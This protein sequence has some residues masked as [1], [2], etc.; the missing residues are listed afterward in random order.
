MS[1][2]N[3]EKY[4]Y[5][6]LDSVLTQEDVSVD[7]YVRDDGSTD[8]TIDI[9]QKY[10]REYSNVHLI[11]DGN[12]V[13]PGQSFY[14]LMKYISKN[15]PHDFYA[16]SDQDDIWMP[17]KLYVGIEKI[18]SIR[19]PALYASNQWLYF[20]GEIKGLRF[21]EMDV[22]LE[23]ELNGNDISGCT[24]VFNHDMAKLASKKE[25]PDKMLL[26]YRLHDTMLLLIALIS[27]KFVFD[28]DS[29]IK[30]RIHKDNAVGIK[31]LGLIGKLKRVIKPGNKDRWWR[32]R[33]KTARYLVDNFSF[34]QE[35][36]LQFLRLYSD[37]NKSIRGRILLMNNQRVLR[38]I[39]ESKFRFTVKVLLG[40]V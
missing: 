18:K 30:Y 15:Y 5:E 8:S 27:G 2:Y 10:S 13:G 7:L 32:A 24:M 34:T 37:Y 28:D 35:D 40:F 4:L 3:G 22:T 31:K 39:G 17:Q 1:T 6:Q 14:M 23:K 12:N 16:F 29:Y 21:D 19:K 11:F 33:S 25:L 20:D 9:L 36:D 26:D 38:G